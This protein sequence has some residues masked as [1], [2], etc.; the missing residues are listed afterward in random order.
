VFFTNVIQE[1]I[2]HFFWGGKS[3]ANI[4]G[5]LSGHR[6]EKWGHRKGREGNN[7]VLEILLFSFRYF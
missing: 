1:N 5:Y 4:R 7:T 6:K 3:Y 2:S